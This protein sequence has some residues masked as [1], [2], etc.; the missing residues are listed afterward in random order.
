MLQM[1]IPHA[2]DILCRVMREPLGGGQLWYGSPRQGSIPP[3]SDV[4]GLP[5]AVTWVH[6]EALL[7]TSL[8]SFHQP[9]LQIRLGVTATWER[10][11]AQHTAAAE[12]RPLH[13]SLLS[14]T[15]PPKPLVHQ[16]A[17]SRRAEPGA[18]V[19]PEEEFRWHTEERIFNS[20]VLITHQKTS[21]SKMWFQI[22]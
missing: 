22:P 19:V 10:D 6:P 12:T 8:P 4:A 17:S 9:K 3:H 20:Y 16:S 2:E 1:T 11:A 14:T 15:Q 18:A 7:S 13:P 21:K 5:Q